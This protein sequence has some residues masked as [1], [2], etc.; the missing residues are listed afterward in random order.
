MV[1]LYC[2]LMY[3]SIVITHHEACI[4]VNDMNIMEPNTRQVLKM[5]QFNVYVLTHE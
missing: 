4:P 2:L 1:V 3:F 5:I